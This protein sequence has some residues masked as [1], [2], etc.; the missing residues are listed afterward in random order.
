MLGAVVSGDGKTM[1]GTGI[2]LAGSGYQGFRVD[3]DQAYVCHGKG[4]GAQ[5]QRVTFPDGF[6]LHLGHGDSVGLCPGQVQ[7]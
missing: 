4:G 7:N 2:P 6:E 5:T 1:A 3:I